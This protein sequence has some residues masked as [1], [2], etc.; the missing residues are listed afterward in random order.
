MF[1]TSI[2][3]LSAFGVVLITA[4][5][6]PAGRQSQFAINNEP[7]DDL[8][9]N[10]FAFAANNNAADRL[11]RE[12]PFAFARKEALLAAP[13]GTPFA[14]AASGHGSSAGR[15]RRESPFAFARSGH[16][17]RFALDI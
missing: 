9:K 8:H 3:L 4:G 16:D 14:F 1:S 11:R 7:V 10:Q 6:N 5:I 2:L 13:L 17:A 15:L 12:S